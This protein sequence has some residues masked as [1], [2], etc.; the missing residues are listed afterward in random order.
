MIERTIYFEQLNG[1]RDK[2]FIK[3]LTGMRRVGKSTLIDLFTRHLVQTGVDRT[4]ILKSTSELPDSFQLDDY[5]SLTDHVL[6]WSENKKGPLY[7]FLDE[8]GRI[9]EWERAINGFHAMGIFDLILTDRNADMLSSE[10]ST[11][12]GGT[13]WRYSCSPFFIC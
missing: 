10:L 2:P 8:V 13:L 7:L 9:K 11:L 6:R 1:Y 5:K 3:V 12:F 4:Q